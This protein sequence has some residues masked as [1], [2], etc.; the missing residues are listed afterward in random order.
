MSKIRD[1]VLE[2]LEVQAGQGATRDEILTLLGI[3]ID[4]NTRRSVGRVLSFQMQEGNVVERHG[5]F[6][7]KEFVSRAAVQPM[8][9]L[10]TNGRNPLGA[11]ARAIG[12][13]NLAPFQKT[14]EP[15]RLALYQAPME[16]EAVMAIELVQEN[17][18][19]FR[20]P[21]ANYRIAINGDSPR[22]SPAQESYSNIINLRIYLSDGQALEVP[23]NPRC[24]VTVAPLEG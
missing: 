22:W 2:A 6:Y 21:L 4:T 16:Y 10:P 11:L 19:C 9:D 23:T 17:G 14:R 20:L 15:R 8:P 7:L 3:E 5:K 13:V 12:K 1:Q 18:A 24:P